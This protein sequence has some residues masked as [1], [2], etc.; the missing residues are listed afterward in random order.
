MWSYTLA[1]EPGEYEYRFVVDRVLAT[2]GMAKAYIA[3]QL[4]IGEASV[5]RILAAQKK[6]G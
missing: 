2:A 5:Y 3:H 6:S 1:I 4:N